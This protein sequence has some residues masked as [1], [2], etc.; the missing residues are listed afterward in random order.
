MRREGQVR[1]KLKQVIFRHRKKFVEMGLSQV[2]ENCKHNGVVRL[3]IHTGNR[4]TIRVCRYVKDGDWNNRVCDSTM[5]GEEQ[6]RGCP[7][8]ECSHT[9]ESLK[10]E[11]SQKLGLGDSEVHAGILAKEYPDIIAL[12]WV[13]GTPQPNDHPSNVSENSILAFLGS[14]SLEDFEDL[15]DSFSGG[16]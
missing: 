16:A 15:E 5:G 9:P 8:F 4:A 7:F 6:A 2:P 12:M 1:H 13:L 14:D 3:P 11:F 10:T